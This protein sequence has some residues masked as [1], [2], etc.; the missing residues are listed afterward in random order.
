MVASSEGTTT[1]CSARIERDPMQENG[2]ATGD[3]NKQKKDNQDGPMRYL[4]SRNKNGK[5]SNAVDC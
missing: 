1:F 4:I 5:M 2:V 3:G